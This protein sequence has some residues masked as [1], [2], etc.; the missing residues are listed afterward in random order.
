[1]ERYNVKSYKRNPAVDPKKKK[2]YEDLMPIKYFCDICSFKTKRKSHLD[3]H[4]AI[5]RKKNLPLYECNIC[6][7]KTL[8]SGH[9]SLHQLKHTD[10]VIKCS[11][12]DYKSTSR[13]AMK[14]HNR[15]KHSAVIKKEEEQTEVTECQICS[16]KTN[17][18]SAMRRHLKVH[19]STEDG[20]LV[21]VFQCKLCAY[22]TVKKMHYTRH[23]LI[24]HSEKRPFLCDTCGRGFKRNDALKQHRMVHV[25]KEKRSWAYH[26]N[27]CGKGLRSPVS[28]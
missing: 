27:V 22:K 15:K 25:E 20:S 6:N 7:F 13:A 28:I 3:K 11:H 2:Q 12:C 9:L 21:Y 1:M 24:V 4:K 19:E 16:Y 8:R 17:R 26:C 23:M 10:N 5:H 18:P 14:Y